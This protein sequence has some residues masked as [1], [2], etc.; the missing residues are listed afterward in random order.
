V[1]SVAQC[2]SSK[3]V[4]LSSPSLSSAGYSIVTEHEPQKT[5]TSQWVI[6]RC[7]STQRKLARHQ[8]HAK[9][10]QPR[11]DFTYPPDYVVCS[12]TC[13]LG[14]SSSQSNHP[15]DTGAKHVQQYEGAVKKL[16]RIGKRFDQMGQQGK[17]STNVMPYTYWYT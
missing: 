14:Q 5:D 10:F 3:S 9:A 4:P 7:L 16:N 12:D 6:Q 17:G 8:A 13:T 1:Q 11:L 15:K 2:S